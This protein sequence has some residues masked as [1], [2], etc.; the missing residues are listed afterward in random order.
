ML[1]EKRPL[2][3]RGNTFSGRKSF[4]SVRYAC[5]PAFFSCLTRLMHRFFPT[6]D[7]CDQ[8]LDDDSAG[9]RVLPPVF[10]EF[11]RLK[12]FFGPV[13]TFQCLDDNSILKSALES[14]TWV[15]TNAGRVAQVL[16]VAVGASQRAIT[17]APVR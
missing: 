10:K 13:F 8:H 14:T 17:D 3:Y 16:V 4:L 1:L 5:H 12:C 7:L 11:G 2:S 9:F 15:D 6:T